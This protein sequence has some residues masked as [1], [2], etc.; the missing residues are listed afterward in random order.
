LPRV[1]VTLTAL[2]P[3]Q[4]TATTRRWPAATGA[5]KARSSCARCVTR[6]GGALDVRG[7][8]VAL[9]AAICAR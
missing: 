7:V 3:P 5:P 6:G 2:V 4:A 1:S 9:K 8:P